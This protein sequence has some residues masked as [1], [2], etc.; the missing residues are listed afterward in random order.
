MKFCP[1]IDLHGGQV[2]Q[3]VGG[4]L[5]DSSEVETNFVSERPPSYYAELYRDDNLTGGHV[6]MLGPGNEAAAKEA[7][8]AWPGGLQVGGGITAENAQNWLAEGAAQVIMT[9]YI[10]RDG[11]LVLENLRRVAGL[12]GN[13]RLVLDLSCRKRDGEYW[14]VTDRWQKFTNHKVNA[15]TLN[16]LAEYCSEFLVHA[17]DVE[18]K[19]AG[20]DSELLGILAEH[21]PLSCVYAGGISTFTDIE[22]ISEGGSGQI[23]YTIGSAL[24]IF[25]GKMS[26]RKVIEYTESLN[27]ERRDR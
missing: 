20:I 6:I 7:L 9:S 8:N 11:E 4:S 18:G 26:Y 23:S 25:G 1:C 15:E 16:F 10:F 22:Q 2:K 13:E 12:V 24:D 3:I 27:N 21:S 5:N 14:I 19:Q 17:V